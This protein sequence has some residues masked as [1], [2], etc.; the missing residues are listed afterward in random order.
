MVIRRQVISTGFD[1]NCNAM[2]RLNFKLNVPES[3]FI[4]ITFITEGGSYYFLL[5][6]LVLQQRLH[7][8]VSA[9]ASLVLFDHHI[10][11]PGNEAKHDYLRTT[12][13]NRDTNLLFS[14]FDVN[15]EEHH[16]QD[17]ADGTNTDVCNAEER[18]LAAK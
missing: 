2:N 15:K 1:I 8:I 11:R 16:A 12:T 10:I 5:F 9:F 18:V 6:R 3:Q 4:F 7:V 13:G 17:K 14:A